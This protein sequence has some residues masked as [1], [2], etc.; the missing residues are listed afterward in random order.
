R[1][2]SWP[3]SSPQAQSIALYIT[4]YVWILQ[5]SG[6]PR[7]WAREP[8]GVHGPTCPQIGRSIPAIVV[9]PMSRLT[10]SPVA[11]DLPPTPDWVGPRLSERGIDLRERPCAKPAEV[12]ETAGDADVVRVMGR[13]PVLTAEVLLHLHRCRVI[14]R[15]GTGT[16][17]IPL[18]AATHRG[19]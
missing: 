13:S 12:E 2:R 15:T 18:D 7:C 11:N 16:D 5:S 8:E 17:N 6:S 10:V 1:L 3:S 19:I 9:L 4:C 14:L